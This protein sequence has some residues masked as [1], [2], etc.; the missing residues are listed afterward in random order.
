MAERFQIG[1][2]FAHQGITFE[3]QRLLPNGEVNVENL[4]TGVTVTFSLSRLTNL[5]FSGELKFATSR[6]SVEV[7][8]R[9]LSLGDMDEKHVEEA[10]QRLDAIQPLVSCVGRTR[11]MV[12]AR[13]EE[14]GASVASLYRW[15]DMYEASNHD[16]RSLVADY[17]QTGNGGEAR[18]DPLVVKIMDAVIDELYMVK[19]GSDASDVWYEVT[20]RVAEE[21]R[22]RHEGEKLV[23]PSLSTVRRHIDRRDI[24]ERYE[25]RKGKQAA[26]RKFNQY[27]QLERPNNLGVRAVID[28]TLMDLV[29]VD[30]EDGLP[31]G[32]MTFTYVMD[33]AA[34]YPLGYYAGFEPPSFYA[35]M[36]CLYHGFRPKGDVQTT[37]GTQHDWLLY[38]VP[39]GLVVD[40]GREFVGRDLKD[41]GDSLGFGIVPCAVKKP[42]QKG[43]EERFFRTMNTGLLHGLPG[44][45]FSSFGE[46]GDYQSEEQACIG[47]KQIDALIHVFLLDFYAERYHRGLK[48]VPARRLESLMDMGYSPRLPQSEEDLRILLGKTEMRTV[49]HYGVEFECLRYNCPELSEVRAYLKGEQT[50]IKVHPSDL[51]H[52]N[53]FDPFG[54]K[55]IR[56]PTLAREYTMGL[57][58]WKHRVIQRFANLELGKVDIEALALAKRRIR[59]IVGNARTAQRSARSRVR[60][61]RMETNGKP[62]RELYPPQQVPALPASILSTSTSDHGIVSPAV[63]DAPSRRLLF[64][65]DGGW[66]TDF[67]L[68]TDRRSSES[69]DE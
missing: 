60:A 9:S 35:V 56:V 57:S 45:T 10:R 6:V 50:K 11:A 23:A 27:G 17:E 53:V 18:V 59:E 5:L 39:E 28:H 62:T 3:V 33:D 21:N 1:T 8:P 15:L 58:L 47:L 52:I 43:T 46:R 24:R 7:E 69:G 41:A 4:S 20:L 38:G 68:G 16:L 29:V 31:L 30:D 32:R 54:G 61:A 55:Y 40:N 64:G 44:T 34:A 12:K 26:Q 2:L 48:G 66:G 65:G 67:S 13:S 25:V 49:Q 42:W 63:S 36:E 14:C 51:S 19:E 22:V 37:Y